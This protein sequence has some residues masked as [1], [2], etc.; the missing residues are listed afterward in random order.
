MAADRYHITDEQ[1]EMLGQ[2]R[3]DLRARRRRLGMSSKLVGELVGVDATHIC[4]VETGRRALS[5]PL[6]CAIAAA[7]DL[8]LTVAVSPAR[9]V[10]T[11]ELP[12]VTR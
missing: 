1:A 8:R 7:L 6:L 12:G 2:L 11:V 4:A 10:V 9:P 3:R 5:L